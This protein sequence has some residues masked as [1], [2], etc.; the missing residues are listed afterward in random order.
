MPLEK[1]KFVALSNAAKC[2]PC[3]RS[4]SRY[5]LTMLRD[6]STN[7][8]FVGSLM[9]SW[10]RD[11]RPSARQMRETTVKTAH[12]AVYSVPVDVLSGSASGAFIA[13]VSRGSARRD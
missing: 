5:K 10:R 4:D 11:C 7:C 12:F 2:C 8:G 3:M 6:F 1:L 13:R 9:L